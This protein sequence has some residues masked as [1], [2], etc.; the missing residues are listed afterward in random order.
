MHRLIPLP[1]LAACAALLAAHLL[2]ARRAAER[3]DPLPSWNDGAAKK[4]L[5]DFVAKV[6]D[7]NGTD[8][9]PPAERIATFD[10]DGTLWC[11]QPMYFQ[12][13]F[14]FERVRELAA[15]HP[16]WKGKQPFKAVIDGDRKAMAK[17]T[18]KEMDQL[19]AATSA[20]MTPEEFKATAAKWLGA[21]KHPRFKRPYK[22]LVYQPQLELM[23]H[24]RAGGF[25]VFIVSGG[26][27]DFIRSY[28]EG[29]Y[30]VPPE[31]V[32]G[33][34]AKTRYDFKD[35]VARLIKLPEIQSIDDGP[36]KPININWHI[37]RRP[38]LAFGNS[39]GDKQMLEYTASGKGPRL[40]LLLHHDDA[41]REYAYDRKSRVGRLDKAWDE[42]V[43][44]KWVVVS[45]KKDFKKVFPFDK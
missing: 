5:L 37:G 30:G 20:G 6:T 35:D 19:F 4:A 45:M 31:Q 3:P 40:M 23:K 17:F 1:A 9:V 32:V 34:S 28:A 10:N 12:V 27:T 16:E 26:G 42:A 15:A 33:T 22:E 24:L 39:D 2:P 41:E 44:R 8:Y 29:A 13:V 18:E 21:S 14:V 36:G 43:R 25:K 11:E 38:T 7:K